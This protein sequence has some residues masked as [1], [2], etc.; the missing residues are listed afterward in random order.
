MVYYVIH[1]KDIAHLN[2]LI[3]RIKKIPGIREAS[4]KIATY[5][6]KVEPKYKLR[7]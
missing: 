2:E 4:V 7:N 3:E 5:L 6:V 1:A